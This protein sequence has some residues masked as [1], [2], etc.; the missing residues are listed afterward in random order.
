MVLLSGHHRDEP[1][2]G[3][4][5]VEVVR[6]DQRGV[7]AGAMQSYVERPRQTYTPPCSRHRSA[8]VGHPQRGLRGSRATWFPMA[9]HLLEG[10]FM[11]MRNS[12]SWSAS[13]SSCSRSAGSPPA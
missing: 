3:R 5:D 13:A 2:V 9:I 1:T 8:A 7:Y 4:D 10:L 11:G 12:R 6:T